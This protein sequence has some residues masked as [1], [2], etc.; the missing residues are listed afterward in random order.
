MWYL[1]PH[2]VIS[3][4]SAS[5]RNVLA[6]SRLLSNKIQLLKSP[7]LENACPDMFYCDQVFHGCYTQLNK[8][9]RLRT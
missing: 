8:C 2:T 3:Q 1:K 5:V 6:H 4:I 7:S 9:A